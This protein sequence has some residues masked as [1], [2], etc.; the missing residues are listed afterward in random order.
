MREGEADIRRG[1]EGV[2]NIGLVRVVGTV[3]RVVGAIE[4]V[5]QLSGGYWG[6]RFVP[7]KASAGN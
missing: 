3:E 2:G 6:G 4:R 7:R 5:V 1:G